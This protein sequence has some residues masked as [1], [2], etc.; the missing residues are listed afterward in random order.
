MSIPLF[1]P[2]RPDLKWVK[3]LKK[4]KNSVISL[5]SNEHGNIYQWCKSVSSFLFILT[6]I[7]LDPVSNK[8]GIWFSLFRSR[9]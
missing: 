3:T 1:S 8:S 4:K 9:Q 2:L 6:V 5:M 7:S